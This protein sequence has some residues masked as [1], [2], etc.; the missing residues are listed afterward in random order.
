VQLGAAVFEPVGFTW[1]RAEGVAHHLVEQLVLGVDFQEAHIGV[2][3]LASREHLGCVL[4]VVL[5][6]AAAGVVEV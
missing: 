1:H 6:L 4:M 3:A 2:L 5:A